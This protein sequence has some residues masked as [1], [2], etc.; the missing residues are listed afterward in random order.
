MIKE[1]RKDCIADFQRIQ[2]GML[3]MKGASCATDG[4][5]RFLAS[6]DRSFSRLKHSLWVDAY[7]GG[8]LCF[9]GVHT[10]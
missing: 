5:L 10:N 8:Q 3:L 6:G 1:A 4:L 2:K 9:K 7:R